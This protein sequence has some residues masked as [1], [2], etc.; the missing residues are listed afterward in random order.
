MIRREPGRIVLASMRNPA[1]RYGPAGGELALP[2]E[3]RRR[4]LDIAIGEFPERDG[5]GRTAELDSFAWPR[6][7]P[8]AALF[9]RLRAIPDRTGIRRTIASRRPLRTPGLAIAASYLLAVALTLAVGDPVG[10]GREA[11]ADLLLAAD[12]HLIDPAARAG[13]VLRTEFG[14]RFGAPLSTLSPLAIFDQP[15]DLPTD[16]IQAWFRRGVDETSEAVRSLGG[17]LPTPGGAWVG[18]TRDG[19]GPTDTEDK[20]RPPTNRT[21]SDADPERTFA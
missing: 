17:L 21:G 13:A 2:E 14:K 8:S 1:D 3:L 16:R 15:L 9:E 20:Q 6:L 10:A 18:E 4:L 5:D 12:E 11:S 19:A 7:E